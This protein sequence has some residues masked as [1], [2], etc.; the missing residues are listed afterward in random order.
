M[1][2]LFRTHIKSSVALILPFCSCVPKEFTTIL[3]FLLFSLML[4]N[5][6]IPAKKI[7]SR[8][9]PSEEGVPLF[10]FSS[11]IFSNSGLIHVAPGLTRTLLWRCRHFL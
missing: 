1:N 2:I 9:I 6:D 4:A 5:N 3:E 7:V 8:G 10:I 11:D